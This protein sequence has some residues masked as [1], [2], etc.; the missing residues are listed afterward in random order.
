MKQIKGQVLLGTVLI[1]LSLGLYVAQ[2]MIFHAERDTFFYLF[3]DL[4]FVPI[5]L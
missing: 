5:S 4:A 1:V 2:I 3:Q